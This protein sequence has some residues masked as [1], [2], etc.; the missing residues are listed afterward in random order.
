M[1]GDY[2]YQKNNE[3]NKIIQQ[4]KEKIDSLGTKTTNIIDK[5]L[6]MGIINFKQAKT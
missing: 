1:I 6:S 4:L 5:S 2:L 3:F